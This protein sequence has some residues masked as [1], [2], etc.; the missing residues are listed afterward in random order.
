MEGYGKEN[1]SFF[2]RLQGISDLLGTGHGSCVSVSLVQLLTFLVCNC[3]EDFYYKPARTVSLEANFANVM[4]NIKASEL[5][6]V[7]P[8][9]KS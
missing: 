4:E 1:T 5:V 2:P 8:V 7:N 9:P 6:V 3:R